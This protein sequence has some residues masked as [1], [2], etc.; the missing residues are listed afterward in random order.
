M[1]VR[2]LVLLITCI[3]FTSFIA[4]AQTEAMKDVINNLALYHKKGDIK[5][6]GEAKKSVDASFKT[7]IDSLDVGKIVYK[8][9][10]YSTVL[11]V[12]SVNKLG[13]PDTLL[14][15]TTKM[16]NKLLANHKIYRYNIQMNYTRGC[17]ANVYQRKGFDYY[18]K[19][20][21]RLA[22]VNFNI[23]KKYVPAA[24][25]LNVYLANIYYKLGNYRTA[26]T[27]YDTVLMAKIPRLE[28]IQSAASIYKSLGDT[29]R[30]LQIVQQGLEVYPKD[31]FLLFEEAN[32]F[33]NKKQYLWL[34]PLLDDL[35]AAAPNDASVLFMAA[36]C[37]DHLN[38][39]DRAELLYQRVI[40]LNSTDYD[41]IFNLGLLY[42]KKA[43]HQKTAG[44]YQA[45]LTQ[46]KIWLEKA[47]EIAPN[48]EA[49]LKSLQMLYLQCG[50]KNRLQAINTKL[51][52]VTN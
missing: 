34:K 33:N 32:I 2:K 14:L 42:L 30:A 21:Y 20:N 52:Q 9:M 19:N 39:L 45:N 27:Y 1:A 8:A 41:P 3:C 50:D 48:N 6:L 24:H 29:T 37:C 13:M 16:V 36:N 5:Y 12:D 49:C 23:A 40:E 25:E 43:I 46:S 44:E 28:N 51:N 17:M 15:Q 10:V 38:D 7:R 35:E 22:I 26:V 11:Y 47:N 31:K 4:N 18:N